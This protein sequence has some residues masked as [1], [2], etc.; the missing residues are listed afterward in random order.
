MTSI[1]EDMQLK[2][3]QMSPVSWY[4][5]PLI[6]VGNVLYCS[7]FSEKPTLCLSVT[8]KDKFIESNKKKIDTFGWIMHD[9]L[10]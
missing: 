4:N 1:H 3:E 6:K 8:D 9:N 2:P 7:K 10:M 5:D